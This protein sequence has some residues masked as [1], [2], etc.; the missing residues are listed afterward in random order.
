M[1]DKKT[2]LKS[3]TK[4]HHITNIRYPYANKGDKLNRYVEFELANVQTST[5]NS[6]RRLMHS[7]IKT[8]GF[9]TE[10]YTAC[11]IEVKANDTPLHNQYILHRLS[12]VPINVPNPENFDVDDY[13]FII[14]VSN[15]TNSIIEITTAD[16]QIKQISTNKFLPREDVNKFFPPDPFTGDH[17]YLDILKP[18]NFVPSKNVSQDVV[19]EMQK[20]FTKLKT[21]DDIMRFHIEGKACISNAIENG[22]FSAVSCASYVN[23]C[24][25]N[26]AS[27]ALKNY[28]NTE[29]ETAK[30]KNITPMTNEQYT[31]R[32]DL[33]E[34]ARSFYTNSKNEPN[35][36]TF[37]IKTIGVIPP[38]IIFHRAIDILK[39]K[40]NTFLNN[41]ISKNED[42]ITIA[43]SKQL[44][45]GY[46]ITVMNEDD[47]LGNIIQTHLCM[48]YAEYTLPKERQLLKYIGYK[49]PHPLEPHIIFSIQGQND[50]FDELIT[51]TMKPGCIEIVRMLNSI[52]NELEGTPYF[53]NE[54]KSI[55]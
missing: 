44:N 1:S 14:D 30:L 19:N 40:I 45:G 53:I 29:N 3:K 43:P 11:Q 18:K 23:T 42:I 16:F 32:F 6:I 7:H 49:K 4:K 26:K 25:P 21:A 34:K 50:N 31:R 9:R 8:V 28:I 39:D 33:T 55:S 38:L 54:L 15:N 47:T 22:H 17:I 41:L 27:I 20:E 2:D 51:T 36:F 35:L 37:K 24:D 46:D 5:S 12:M 10:P 48:L 52:Q 13:L